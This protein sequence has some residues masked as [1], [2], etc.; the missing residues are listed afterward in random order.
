[1][2]GIA[3]VRLKWEID[4]LKAKVNWQIFRILDVEILCY[5]DSAALV[6]TVTGAT[7]MLMVTD[8][9]NDNTRI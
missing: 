1:M 3:W 9:T 7:I 5:Q 6:S 2:G 8:K 4:S